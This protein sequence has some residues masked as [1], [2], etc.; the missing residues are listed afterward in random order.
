M[1][2][3]LGDVSIEPVTDGRERHKELLLMADEQWDMIERY[4]YR[5]DMYAMMKDGGAVCVCVVTDEGDGVLEIK[6]IAT[7]PGC[8]GR[9]Y[10]MAMIEF[11]FERYKGR[12]SEMMVGTGDS[13]AILPFYEQCGFKRHHVVKDFFTD[14]YDHPMYEGGVLLADMVYLSRDF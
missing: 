7:A 14:N 6:N 2:Y 12:F 3:Y 5:G 9:G 8:R 10:A 4:L 1:R 11:L 13:P